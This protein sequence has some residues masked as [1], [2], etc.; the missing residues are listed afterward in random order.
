MMPKKTINLLVRIALFTLVLC[1]GTGTALVIGE[2]TGLALA[3]LS[4]APVEILVKAPQPGTF[5]AALAGNMSGVYRTDDYGRSWQRLSRG[6]TAVIQTLA[7]HPVNKQLVYASTLDEANN[8]GSRLWS[9]PDGGKRWNEITLNLPANV[10]GQPPVIS[11]L[12]IDPANPEVLLVGTQG[13][14]LYR[15]HP[16]NGRS[17]LVGGEAMAKLYVKQVVADPNNRLYV[18]STEGLFRVDGV[19][20]Y[21]IEGLPDATVSLAVDPA[22]S[23]HLYAGTAGYG[24]YHSEDGGRNWHA[25][26]A[27]LGWQPGLILRT[28]TVAVDQTNPDHLALALA[29]GVGDQILGEG[30][31]ESFNGGQHWVKIADMDEVV[32]HLLLEEGGIY[33][34]TAQGLSRYGNPLPATWL[35]SS[36]HFNSLANP[37]GIQVLILV[38]TVALASWV[39]LG[40]LNWIPGYQ[41]SGL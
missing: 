18:I 26:N 31:Y 15:L 8:S 34:A 40:R 28:P 24:L 38:L 6:P 29:Y 1:L 3:D 39:L 4:N 30:V 37:T 32:T 41:Q 36:F 22:N 10:T 13:A 35:S 5:Y 14:G 21:K 27:G 17:D 25:L 11:T 12:A 2:T 33:V 16:D 20:G 23:D 7:I 19:T 9:S